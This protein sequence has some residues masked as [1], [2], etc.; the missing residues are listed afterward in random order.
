LQSLE[1]AKITLQKETPLYQIID[2]PTLPLYQDKPGKLTSLI[3]GGFL[4]GFLI[5]MILIFKKLYSQI[6]TSS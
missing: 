3:I 6:K 4:A 1:I 2:E 5:C